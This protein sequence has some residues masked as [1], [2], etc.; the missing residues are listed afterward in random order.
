MFADEQLLQST[1]S[2]V[3]LLQPEDV[4]VDIDKCGQ[5]DLLDRLGHLDDKDSNLLSIVN[6]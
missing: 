5:V 1:D 6:S 3:H 4:V 2:R